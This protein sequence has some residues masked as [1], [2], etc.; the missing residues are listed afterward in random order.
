MAYG[1]PDEPTGQKLSSYFDTLKNKRQSLSPSGVPYTT[2]AALEK[3]ASATGT[4]G[5]APTS[6]PTSAPAQAPGG[7]SGFVGFQQYF[8]A[9]APAIQEQSRQ[10][11]SKAVGAKPMETIT[12]PSA[13]TTS[14]LMGGFSV[15]PEEGSKVMAQAARNAPPKLMGGA[16]LLDQRRSVPGGVSLPG[17]GERVAR[18]ASL[19]QYFGGT[20]ESSYTQATPYSTELGLTQS[21][22]EALTPLAQPGGLQAAGKDAF[23]SMLASGSTQ[24]LAAPTLAREQAHLAGLQANEQ[25]YQK[26]RQE[27]RT[28]REDAALRAQQEASHPEEEKAIPI[29]AP[30]LYDLARYTT[31]GK[32]TLADWERFY[33][34]PKLGVFGL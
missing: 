25:A 26:A 18:E 12:T 6:T 7:G 5:S 23:T 33:E 9:N 14:P 27:A 34:R 22:V 16:T 21:R 8:G 3:V 31:S 24:R 11:F 19:S 13:S 2:G 20:P 1:Q 29:P 4:S 28:A 15:Q 17:L 10:A 32:A 30:S